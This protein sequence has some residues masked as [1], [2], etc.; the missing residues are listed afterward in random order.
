M[1]YCRGFPISEYRKVQLWKIY[2]HHL[3]RWCPLRLEFIDSKLFFSEM[4]EILKLG[5]F[6]AFVASKKHTEPRSWM[7]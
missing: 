1:L 2:E 3:E 6:Q 4:G 7:W 5:S